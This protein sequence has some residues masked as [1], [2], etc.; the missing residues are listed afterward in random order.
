[1]GWVG[2]WFACLQ[3]VLS[4]DVTAPSAPGLLRY[5]SAPYIFAYPEHFPPPPFSYVGQWFLQ[6][7]SLQTFFSKLFCG[8]YGINL[9]MGRNTGRGKVAYSWISPDPVKAGPTLG[10]CCCC[11]HGY[12]LDKLVMT[13]LRLVVICAWFLVQFEGHP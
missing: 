10:V 8:S 13:W 7:F 9:S 5:V 6:S 1:M 3:V 4:R 12:E 11:S 2:F